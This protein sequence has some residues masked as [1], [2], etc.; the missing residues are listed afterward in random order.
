M[1]VRTISS[2]KCTTDEVKLMLIVGEGRTFEVAQPNKGPVSIRI[3]QVP[4]IRITGSWRSRRFWACSTFIQLLFP[5]LVLSGCGGLSVSG[6]QAVVATPAT[7]AFGS[8]AV[9]QSAT[10]NITLK[11][12]GLT[13]VEID[14]LSM[15]G[16][17]FSIVGN[18]FPISL[19]ADA[20]VTLQ[21]R[22]TPT[23]SG[24]T[25]EPLMITSS[26][27]ADPASIAEVTGTGTSGASGVPGKV[28]LSW[29]APNS[30]NDPIV[31]YNVY[32]SGTGTGYALLNSA[33]ESSTSYVDSGVQSGS[34]YNYYV[35][36]VDAAGDSSE[37]SNLTTVTV[38]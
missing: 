11:N 18:T 6:K 21:V 29:V 15:S 32:R 22:F 33:I 13:T 24:S 23:A 7:L 9:G 10:A 1:E 34:V 38:P 4:G 37:P 5:V 19:A 2:G 16:A 3:G 17:A 25:T 14:D 30:P 36:S 8:V 31:G 12:Q 28:Q 26:L 35:V 27:S 20:S